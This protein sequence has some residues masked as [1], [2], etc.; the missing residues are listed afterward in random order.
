MMTVGALAMAAL[1]LFVLV[2]SRARVRRFVRGQVRI[3]RVQPWTSS[4]ESTA[5]MTRTYKVHGTVTTPEGTFD[6]T[7]V[8]VYDEDVLG[9]QGVS[10]PCRY[11]PTDPSRMTLDMSARKGV[12]LQDVVLAGVAVVCLGVAWLTR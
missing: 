5:T 1:A 8:D 2:N 7:S 10:V 4:G 6:A 9:K 11:D 12:D 3:S